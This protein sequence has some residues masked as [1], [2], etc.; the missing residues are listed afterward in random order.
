LGY[1][2]ELIAQARASDI[3]AMKTAAEWKVKADRWDRANSKKMEKVRAAK[4]L[5]KTTTPGSA[6]APGAARQAAYAS[7]RDA[8]KRGD[9]DAT[10]RVLDS[11]FTQPK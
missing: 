4:T 6:K 9:R 2:P 10:M 11:F 3:L 5:P 1:S 8:M 7:D